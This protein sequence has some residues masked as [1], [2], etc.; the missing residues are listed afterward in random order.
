MVADIEASD[1][2][3]RAAAILAQVQQL[4]GRATL[5]ALLLIDAL[6]AAEDRQESL[7]AEEVAAE[8][9][10]S[11]PLVHQST[12]YRLLDRLEKAALVEHV[13][14]GHGRAV[15]HLA[16]EPH[17]HLV[18][19]RCGAETRAGASTLDRISRTLL[20]ATGF[21][22]APHHFAI[23]GVCAICVEEEGVPPEG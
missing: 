10:R 8:V 19:E 7:T 14:L 9:H 5:G 21:R 11:N 13:H 18:C 4:G 2:S 20:A 22:S 1:R 17:L 16:D 6:V 3:E 23:P 12:I 15:Y